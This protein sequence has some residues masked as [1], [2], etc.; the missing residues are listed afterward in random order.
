MSET[1]SRPMDRLIAL[2]ADKAYSSALRLCGNAADACDLVQ[3]SFLRAW[4][5]AD[6]YDPSRDFGAWLHRLIYRVYLNERRARARLREVPLEES[7]PDARAHSSPLPAE[8]ADGPEAELAKRDLKARVTRALSRLPP[9][10][11]ACV[12]LVDVEGLSYEEAARTLAWPV[13]SVAG[14]LF[15]ARRML[16]E[17]LR[18]EAEG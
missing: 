17:L 14:R 1:P 12:S 18:E 8:R 5:K 7:A 9:D 11:R 16:R 6:L 3:E 15:R 13:G 2:H 10:S 4:K